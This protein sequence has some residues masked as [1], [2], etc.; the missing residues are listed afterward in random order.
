MPAGDSGRGQSR[1]RTHQA[2]RSTRPWGHGQESSG[3]CRRELPHRC[4]TS[5]VLYDTSVMHG[6]PELDGSLA[7]GL[8]VNRPLR[9]IFLLGGVVLS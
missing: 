5:V 3:L 2:R 8:V 4:G 6:A 7:S 1:R 9:W